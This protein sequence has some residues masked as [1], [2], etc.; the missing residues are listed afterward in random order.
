MQQSLL[1][2]LQEQEVQPVG[3]TKTKKIDVR[4]I[5]ATHRNLPER[6]AEGKFRWDLYYR[7]AVAE[8]EVPSFRQR[9]L[10]ERETF[11]DHYVRTLAQLRGQERL[12]MSAAAKTHLLAYPFPGNLRELANVVESLY[13]FCEGEVRIEDL[14]V[15]LRQNQVFHS[16]KLA[17]VERAH[18]ARAMVFF[19]G[20][21]V[22]VAGALGVSR[23]TLDKK[24]KET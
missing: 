21:K 16:W 19:E 15:R 23:S 5:T 3:S 10:A 20:K 12:V 24:L 6:C 11:V 7:L 2:V 18:I 17:D 14:P 8:I 9:A 13:V 4:V 1:R 22:A